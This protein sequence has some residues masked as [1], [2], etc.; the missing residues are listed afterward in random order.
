MTYTNRHGILISDIEIPGVD[1][2]NNDDTYTASVFDEDIELPGVGAGEIRAPQQV[3]I[4]DLDISGD[5]D[6]IQV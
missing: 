2:N 6:P 4:D 5:P 1:P 3:E